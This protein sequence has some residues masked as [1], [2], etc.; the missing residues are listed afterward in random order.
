MGSSSV[1]VILVDVVTVTKFNHCYAEHHLLAAC[2]ALHCTLAHAATG[3]LGGR[4]FIRRWI[5]PICSDPGNKWPRNCIRISEERSWCQRPGHSM[6]EQHQEFLREDTSIAF[7]S[8][9]WLPQWRVA[10]VPPLV[11]TET[12]CKPEDLTPKLSCPSPSLMVFTSRLL[13]GTK[14]GERGHLW[15]CRVCWCSAVSS[16]RCSVQRKRRPWS[17]GC[18]WWFL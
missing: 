10:Q 8:S 11:K 2:E 9:R 7:K 18:Q 5:S 16:I 1:Q 3:T 12:D 17:S 15:C 4:H 14:K 6:G 13:T